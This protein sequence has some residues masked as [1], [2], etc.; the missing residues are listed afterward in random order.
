MIGQAG[1]NISIPL[2]RDI[3]THLKDLLLMISIGLA[4]EMIQDLRIT[5][6]LWNIQI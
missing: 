4:R 3:P 2:S 1:L 6:I 5:L